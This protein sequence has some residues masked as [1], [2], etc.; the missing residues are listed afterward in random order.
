MRESKIKPAGSATLNYKTKVYELPT[1]SGP[2][3]S[4]S[5]DS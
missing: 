4:R 2:S 3:S 5:T 1:F